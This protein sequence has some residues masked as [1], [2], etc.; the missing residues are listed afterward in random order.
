MKNT[1]GTRCEKVKESFRAR[2]NQTTTV[3]KESLLSTVNVSLAFSQFLPVF[4]LVFSL[5]SME[6]LNTFLWSS[7]SFKVF[8]LPSR[9]KLPGSI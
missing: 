5:C 6:F 2:L 1:W 8:I 4:L 3:N 9:I 7:L